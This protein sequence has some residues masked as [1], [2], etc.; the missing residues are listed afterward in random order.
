[1]Y[2]QCCLAINNTCCIAR[3]VSMQVQ[4]MLQLQNQWFASK[5]NIRLILALNTQCMK[6]HCIYNKQLVSHP[7]IRPK[8]TKCDTNMIIFHLDPLYWWM[9]VNGVL[10]IEWK[11]KFLAIKHANRF[12]IWLIQ[13]LWTEAEHEKFFAVYETYLWF[14]YQNI[15]FACLYC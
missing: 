11:S 9:R 13:R 10:T 7:K 5:I 14:K 6:I 15:L 1:M 8:S 2:L 12:S 3:I 4:H